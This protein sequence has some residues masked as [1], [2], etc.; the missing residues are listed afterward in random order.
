[1]RPREI[2]EHYARVLDMLSSPLRLRYDEPAQRFARAAFEHVA[3]KRLR[4]T[5]KADFRAGKSDLF[6]YEAHQPVALGAAGR[7]SVTAG[8]Q[9]QPATLRR[10]FRP[11]DAASKLL[12]ERADQKRMA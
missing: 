10:G 2:L 6:P 7:I 5:N 3:K 9:D 4:V 8:R 1:M 11:R 12:G